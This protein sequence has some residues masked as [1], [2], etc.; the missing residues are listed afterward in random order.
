MD[1]TFLFF[2]FY[3][4]HSIKEN[5]IRQIKIFIIKIDNILLYMQLEG[6]LT[7]RYAKLNNTKYLDIDKNNFISIHSFILYFFFS[8]EMKP[9]FIQVTK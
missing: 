6:M 3:F 7:S 2:F 1:W 5:P 4:L 9:N 8:N